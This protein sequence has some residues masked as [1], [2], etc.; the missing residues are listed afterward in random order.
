MYKGKHSKDLKKYYKEILDQSPIKPTTGIL[1]ASS[2]SAW[3]AIKIYDEHI[4]AKWQR[5]V[6]AG[7]ILRLAKETAIRRII[8]NI[9]PIF[10]AALYKKWKRIFKS[11]DPNAE[12]TPKNPWEL[13]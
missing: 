2:F 12:N 5:G 7:K 9:Q 1:D 10:K 11:S 3:D 6:S 13:I 4:V 8:E